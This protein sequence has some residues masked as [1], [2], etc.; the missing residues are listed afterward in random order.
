[1]AEDSCPKC[2]SDDVARS[3]RSSRALC[4]ACGHAWNAGPPPV[5]EGDGD[6]APAVRSAPVRASGD[7]RLTAELRTAAADAPLPEIPRGTKVFISYAWRDGKLLAERLD[8]DLTRAGCV[9]WKDTKRI[10]ADDNW[11]EAI[12]MALRFETEVFLYLLTPASVLTGLE[13]DN[14]ERKR[15]VC[16]DEFNYATETLRLPIVPVMAAPGVTPPFRADVKQRADLVGWNE[17]DGVYARG[18]RALHRLL[19][20]AKEKR[21][22]PLNPLAQRLGLIDFSDYVNRKSRL[23]VGRDWLFERL[24]KWRR[25]PGEERAMLLTAGPGFGKSAVV[26]ELL[27]RDES[28]EVLAYHF[29]QRGDVET[30]SP[31]RFVRS[32]AAMIA[33]RLPEYAAR[34]TDPKS[35]LLDRLGSEACVRDPAGLFEEA[36]LYPLRA[37]KQSPAGDGKGSLIVIDGLDECLDHVDALSGQ[38]VLD[39]IASGRMRRFP[40][41]MRVLVTTRPYDA[42]LKP[43]FD[44]KHVRFDADDTAAFNAADLKRYA[45]DRLKGEALVARMRLEGVSPKEALALLLEKAAGV[46]KPLADN[47]DLIESGGKSFAHLRGE[48]AGTDGF[49]AGLL[50]RAQKSLGAKKFAKMRDLL[51][52]LGAAREPVPDA[53]LADALQPPDAGEIEALVAPLGRALAVA[54]SPDGERTRAFDHKSFPDWLADPA[55]SGDLHVSA[56]RGHLLLAQWARRVH[57]SFADHHALSPAGALGAFWLRHAPFHMVSAARETTDPSAPDWRQA[58]DL[59]TDLRFLEARCAASLVHET[60]A[61][62]DLATLHHPDT[63]EERREEMERRET[64][65][66]Y[67]KDLVEYARQFAPNG[68]GR[69]HSTTN[70]EPRTKIPLPTIA[71]VPRLSDEEIARHAARAQA[72]PTAGDRLFAF[73]TFLRTQAAALEE[74]GPRP[75]FVAQHA[76]NSAREGPVAQAAERRL[77]ALG[78]LAGAPADSSPSPSLPISPSREAPPVILLAHASR[79]PFVPR[80]AMQAVLEGHRND[81]NAV[82]VTPDGARAVSGGRDGTVRVWD[83]ATGESMAVLE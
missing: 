82:A 78:L 9:V 42:A 51:A 45:G 25:S 66:N 28:R 79:P 39:V 68:E 12:E 35:N 52:C 11:N 16:R 30:L 65:A 70:R 31:S 3:R 37:L 46:M 41:W 77:A 36:L 8:H 38:R 44:L 59:L 83:L 5:P 71:S 61:D 67:A 75:G 76:Y 27:R 49:H 40:D 56:E 21:A 1:M 72:N 57:D 80:P 63:R 50:A 55:R 58:V 54:Q 81:V 13:P 69:G 33:G 74:F 43:L 7:D 26:A 29:C 32:L 22:L 34:L 47:L 14:K 73:S 6:D 24:E 20:E 19:A 18:L 62:F 60:I 10:R 4:A 53:V 48:K 64:C 23:F 15:S 2:G 17:G